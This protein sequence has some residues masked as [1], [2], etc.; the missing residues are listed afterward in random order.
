MSA[1]CLSIIGIIVNFYIYVSCYKPSYLHLSL[2]SLRSR[3]IRRLVFLKTK[4]EG[5]VVMVVCVDAEQIS[6]NLNPLVFLEPWTAAMTA[7]NLC[8]LHAVPAAKGS[9]GLV[10]N[11][12]M[13]HFQECHVMLCDLM[14]PAWKLHCFLVLCV[15]C[16]FVVPS[17]FRGAAFKFR[18]S[19][20]P[21]HLTICPPICHQTDPIRS[22]DS[23]VRCP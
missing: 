23:V 6:S 18:V 11:A 9:T 4:T 8:A 22:L 2:C 12:S 3:A 17:L 20:S 1:P 19:A 10:G 16:G 5:R 21:K 7:T 14:K 13:W 15:Y